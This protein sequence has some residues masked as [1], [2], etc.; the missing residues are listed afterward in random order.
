MNSNSV[1][2]VLIIFTTFVIG[3]FVLIADVK[4]N[5]Y[6]NQIDELEDELNS[7][8][9][10]LEQYRGSVVDLQSRLEEYE[11]PIGGMESAPEM[12]SESTFQFPIHVDDFLRYTSPYGQ[13]ES[14]FTRSQVYHNGIDIATVWK[15]QVVSVAD[16]EVVDHWPPPS[17]RTSDGGYF[18]GHRVY[19]GMIKIDH[20][21]F[22]SLYAHLSETN[23]FTG[24][25]IDAGETI[26]RVG[27]T[28]ESR[29][30]HLH[31]ELEMNGES[32]NPLL[33]ISSLS[34]FDYD[35]D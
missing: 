32:V 30:H 8:E 3:T 6:I 9:D 7:K 33:Y 5:R 16:G 10:D 13:R 25:K 11:S 26:G 28:G 35:G 20:G 12:I 17:T 24:Q 34:D 31:F 2:Y 19:G 23:V 29:G 18:S 22:T 4:E 1:N 15:A 27:D 14:P 21:N